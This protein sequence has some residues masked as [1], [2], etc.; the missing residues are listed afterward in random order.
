MDIETQRYA[1]NVATMEA[2]VSKNRSG[3]S[4]LTTLHR[5]RSFPKMSSKT[6]V[7]KV[8]TTLMFILK[9]IES[10]QLAIGGNGKLP[11]V[12]IHANF[13]S[14]SWFVSTNKHLELATEVVASI[15]GGPETVLNEGSMLRTDITQVLRQIKE[16]DATAVVVVDVPFG[17]PAQNR[18][19]KIVSFRYVESKASF[20]DSE[21]V[22][23]SICSSPP[24][25]ST[26][27]ILKL[28]DGQELDCGP[29]ARTNRLQDVDESI[30]LVKAT[31]CTTQGVV[32]CSRCAISMGVISQLKSELAKNN[33]L[34][35]ERE[36]HFQLE[37][38]RCER[39]VRESTA[40]ILHG[41]IGDIYTRF[42][43]ERT[44]HTNLKAQYKVIESELR[45]LEKGGASPAIADELAKLR[46][47]VLELEEDKQRK[48]ASTTAAQKRTVDLERQL[49]KAA[50]DKTEALDGLRILQAS[51]DERIETIKSD[52]F[53]AR[54]TASEQLAQLVDKVKELG[55]ENSAT[56]KSHNALDALLRGKTNA[57]EK[58]QKSLIVAKKKYLGIRMEMKFTEDRCTALESS[59]KKSIVRGGVRMRRAVAKIAD[60]DRRLDEAQQAA[61]VAAATAAVVTPPP[62]AANEDVMSPEA[63]S[64]LLNVVSNAIS[65]ERRLQ[66]FVLMARAVPTVKEQPYKQPPPIELESSLS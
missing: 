26:M 15:Y 51:T 27:S 35:E 2:S 6:S 14:E 55:V 45:T 47:R 37:L 63:A 44:Q 61:A 38:K 52:A 50:N 5:Y 60:L 48:K 43:N 23:S 57:L 17:V 1:E 33:Q 11:S 16:L 4:L 31:L 54:R 39:E 46:G 49:K 22:Y 58:E 34:A 56:I 9:G 65:L 18:F 66:H 20:V 62:P 36:V 28:L 53:Q 19:F 13:A 25:R 24:A 32:S 64:A 21:L 10:S 42:E 3:Y 30:G 12:I 8:Q 7:Q 41:D 29:F 40:T 59:L